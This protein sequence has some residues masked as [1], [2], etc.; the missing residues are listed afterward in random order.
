MGLLLIIPFGDPMGYPN[1][2]PFIAVVDVV[3]GG[4]NIHPDP[5]LRM[6]VFCWLYR[7]DG[8]GGGELDSLLLLLLLERV[9]FFLFLDLF[10]DLG[11]MGDMAMVFN[12]CL[13]NFG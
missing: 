9:D 10:V 1:G 11:F 2:D 6:L 7:W 12:L 4:G 3:T 5:A 13:V 8:S